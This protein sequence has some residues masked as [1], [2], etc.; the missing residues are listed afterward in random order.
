[1]ASL[2]QYKERA[3][4]GQNE[5]FYLAAPNRQLALGSPYYDGFQVCIRTASMMT[6]MMNGHRDEWP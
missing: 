4:E 2:A 5:I 1:M 6:I 3:V